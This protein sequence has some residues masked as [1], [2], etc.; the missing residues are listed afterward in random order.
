MCFYN[1]VYIWCFLLVALPGNAVFGETLPFSIGLALARGSDSYEKY[2]QGAEFASN[3]SIQM[4]NNRTFDPP[5]DIFVNTPLTLDII[6]H[7]THDSEEEA[8]YSILALSSNNVIAVIGDLNS[9]ITEVCAYVSN[10]K[11]LPMVGPIASSPAFSNKDDFE[12]FSRVIPSDDLQVSVL[13]KLFEELSWTQVAI[14]WGDESYGN[15]F[16]ESFLET[17]V[18][19]DISVIFQRSFS[20]YED[21]HT[22][23]LTELWESGSS[24]VLI[25]SQSKHVRKLLVQASE[26]RFDTRPMEWVATDAWAGQSVFSTSNAEELAIVTSMLA[27]SVGINIFYDEVGEPY[28]IMNEVWKGS[29]PDDDYYSLV[30]ISVDIPYYAA[31][32]VDAV[33][34]VAHALKDMYTNNNDFSDPNVFID[35]IR[36]VTFNGLSG[37][38]SLD[39]YGD[40]IGTYN[41]YYVNPGNSSFSLVGRSY[42][43]GTLEYDI[44]WAAGKAPVALPCPDGT[45]YDK[46]DVACVDGFEV[47]E[48]I[49]IGIVYPLFV[50]GQ[51]NNAYIESYIA[52]IAGM[53]FTNSDMWLKEINNS[54]IFT[55]PLTD[56][57][58]DIFRR[59]TFRPVVFNTFQDRCEDI[60]TDI[61]KFRSPMGDKIS[62]VIGLPDTACVEVSY[63]LLRAADIPIISTDSSSPVFSNARYSYFFRTVP[64]DILRASSLA[65]FSRE[66]NWTRVAALYS[67]AQHSKIMTEAF[68]WDKIFTGDPNLDTVVK[69]VYQFSAEDDVVIRDNL[70]KIKDDGFHIV[71]L[72]VTHDNLEK[73]LLI[74]EDLSMIGNEYTYLI[75]TEDRVENDISIRRLLNGSF[76]SAFHA[77]DG[78]TSAMS[79]LVE[80]FTF[81]SACF[82]QLSNYGPCEECL[83]GHD[84]DGHPLFEWD[85]D[86]DDNTPGYCIGSEVNEVNEWPLYATS[87]YAVDA[88][89]IGALAIVRTLADSQGSLSGADLVETMQ[90][91][92]LNGL[93][94]SISFKPAT[95]DRENGEYDILNFDDG[96][97]STKAATISFC[98]EN[99]CGDSE[100]ED[101]VVTLEPDST[102]N[103]T[104]VATVDIED[105][106]GARYKISIC[107]LK[108]EGGEAWSCMSFTKV[109]RDGCIPRDLYLNEEYECKECPAD[110]SAKD[111]EQSF[112]TSCGDESC[113]FEFDEKFILHYV[114]VLASIIALLKLYLMKRKAVNAFVSSFLL[115]ETVVTIFSVCGDFGDIGTDLYSYVFVIGSSEL[116]NYWAWY[117]LTMTVA[118]GTSLHAIFIRLRG[119]WGVWITNAQVTNHEFLGCELWMSKLRR[120]RLTSYGAVF[121]ALWED[122]PHLLL[123]F[124]MMTDVIW[125]ISDA[126]TTRAVATSMA[127]SLCMFGYRMSNLDKV[128]LVG[129]MEQLLGHVWEE[130]QSMISE[131]DG[132]ADGTLS[133]TQSARGEKGHAEDPSVAVGVFSPNGVSGKAVWGDTPGEPTTSNGNG[134]RNIP[135]TWKSNGSHVSDRRNGHDFDGLERQ[136]HQTETSSR[137]NG[138]AEIKLSPLVTI[139]SNTDSTRLPTFGGSVRRPV[140]AVE[141]LPPM[142]VGAETVQDIRAP[143]EVR[144]DMQGTYVLDLETVQPLDD[145]ANTTGPITASRRAPPRGKAYLVSEN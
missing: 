91:V 133:A 72:S 109:P 75:V 58:K 140:S 131:E 38:V 48:E 19:F 119:L 84:V 97:K 39:E 139:D 3:L 127:I 29:S 13:C 44:P 4:I 143:P 138:A 52:A 47:P 27:G 70:Q 85:H 55:T 76:T 82:G 81:G 2:A 65:I 96:V 63:P 32:T 35:A 121:T 36:N 46:D 100:S 41:L 124:I 10:S 33:L 69:E 142:D 45:Y 15:N 64:S 120:A 5:F 17:S 103:D 71:Y 25:A 107:P 88:V 129:P 101:E 53:D 128:I 110:T 54:A 51:P 6:A 144:P 20:I 16:A 98:S 116:H 95:R 37:H 26:L 12:M 112:C 66:M 136:V 7:P 30:D 134:I 23:V 125:H 79:S 105:S 74:A 24:I 34:A 132:V 60:A 68:K 14:I 61:V 67:S 49:F 126:D 115:K 1:V 22:A 108:D 9:R 92:E 90:D 93:T 18:G 130:S 106:S 111:H 31:Y 73:V 11:L 28:K 78:E 43:D 86:N 94:G 87:S 123:Y 114:G 59:T 99:R 21:D 102:A 77:A 118:M 50:G 104:A 40:R 56:D 117:T 83:E 42:P 137:Y 141:T 80:D 122:V 135:M 145:I 113:G 8:I 57:E 89:F 62:L